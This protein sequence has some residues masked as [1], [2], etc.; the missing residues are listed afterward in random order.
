MI[1][2]GSSDR[3]V[4]VLTADLT[5]VRRLTSPGLRLVIWLAIIGVIAL[6]F[7]IVSNAE[8]T[9]YHL[10]ATPDIGLAVM[11]SSL[12]AVLAAAAAFQLC[13]PDRRPAWA[14]LPFPAFLVWIGGSGLGCLRT[15][16][17]PGDHAIPP[18]QTGQCLIVILGV[19]LPLSLIFIVL[20]RRGFSLRPK[21]TAITAGFACA[22]AA[23]TVL[24]FIHP[25]DTAVTDL[26]VHAFAVAIV[27]LVN[28]IFGGRILMSKNASILRL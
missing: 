6:G 14:F 25:Y 18:G 28:V 8:A 16:S 11:G 19:S 17:L 9:V 1:G 21:I 24:N 12:T 3:L 26:A 27:V 22:A 23:A 4:Q 13:L 5:P 10:I 7:A 2:F 20:L 15:W